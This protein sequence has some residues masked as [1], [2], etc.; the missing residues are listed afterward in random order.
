MFLTIGLWNPWRALALGLYRTKNPRVRLNF[1]VLEGII[2][3]GDG[4]ARWRNI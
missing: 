4:K 2:E 1:I 3:T